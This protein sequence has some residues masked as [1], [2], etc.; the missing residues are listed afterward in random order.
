MYGVNSVLR[1]ICTCDVFGGE[2]YGSN[3]LLRGSSSSFRC[4]AVCSDWFSSCQ[5]ERQRET[6]T[7]SVGMNISRENV[8]TRCGGGIDFC[9]FF[10]NRP[11]CLSRCC[12]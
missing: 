9:F 10:F 1:C 12:R 3:F 6:S 4:P 8:E 7:I 11:R 5:G 2:V